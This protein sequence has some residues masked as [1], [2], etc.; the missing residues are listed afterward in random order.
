MRVI[1][2]QPRCLASWKPTTRRFAAA[3]PDFDPATLPARFRLGVPTDYDQG[4]ASSCGPNALAECAEFLTGKKLSRLFVY[5]WTRAMEGD[6]DADDGIEIP[7]LVDIGASMGMP[8][9]T[10]WPY[11]LTKLETAPPMSALVE[12]LAHRVTSQKVIADLDHLMYSIAVEQRPVLLGFNVPQSMEDGTGG[13]TATTGIVN[14][15]SAT[16]PSIGGHAVTA[17]SYDK[18]RRAVQCTC[19]YGSGFG[20]GG[21][22]WLGYEHW[23]AGNVRDMRQIAAVS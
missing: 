4:Q 16:D 22:I 8:L 14:V 7:D 13:S 10:S 3:K 21:T 12:A 6:P 20:D 19:H 11:D 15:P 1:G 18:D 17:F 23:F 2:G 9:E 5:Y